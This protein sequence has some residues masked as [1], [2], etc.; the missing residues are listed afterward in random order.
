MEEIVSVEDELRYDS[1]YSMS[2][3]KDELK[4]GV[5]EMRYLENS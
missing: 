4:N 3:M 1:G 5:C 2:G